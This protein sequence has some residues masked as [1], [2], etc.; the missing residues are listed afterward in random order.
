[1]IKFIRIYVLKI[2]LNRGSSELSLPLS[3]ILYLDGHKRLVK[4]MHTF[5]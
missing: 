1:M 5:L 4:D 2:Y 3:L